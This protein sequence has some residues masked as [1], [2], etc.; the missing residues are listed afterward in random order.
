[1]KRTVPQSVFDSPD[2]LRVK[3]TGSRARIWPAHLATCWT[4][5][6]RTIRTMTIGSSATPCRIFWRSSTANP[7]TPIA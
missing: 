3:V 1:M 7:G 6:T 4:Q 2:A 5:E